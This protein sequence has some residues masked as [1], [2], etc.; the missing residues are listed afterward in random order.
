MTSNDPLVVGCQLADY[1]IVGF[2]AEMHIDEEGLVAYVEHIRTWMPLIFEMR[3]HPLLTLYLKPDAVESLGIVEPNFTELEANFP[4]L[5]P[6]E[7]QGS[8]RRSYD[9]RR[10]SIPGERRGSNSGRRDSHDGAVVVRR[11][12]QQRRGSIN[13]MLLPPGEKAKLIAGGASVKSGHIVQKGLA[14]IR[15]PSMQSSISDAPPKEPPPGRGYE[16]RKA[17]IDR[18][19]DLENMEEANSGR[20]GSKDGA[21]PTGL[22]A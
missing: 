15:R 3:K 2:V 6:S 17:R 19:Q 14:S 7:A 5:P 4:L 21:S 11:G 16:R 1:E 10:S 12:S 13:Q 8:R 9:R 22:T 20:R 18:E